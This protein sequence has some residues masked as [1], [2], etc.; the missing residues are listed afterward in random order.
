MSEQD[1]RTLRGVIV[2]LV[3]GPRVART[4]TR[5]GPKQTPKGTRPPVAPAE[6]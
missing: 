4:K 5:K 1:V 6:G 2:R 3:E